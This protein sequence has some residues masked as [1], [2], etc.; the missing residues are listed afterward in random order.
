MYIRIGLVS[1][2]PVLSRRVTSME[3]EHGPAA[4]A[5]SDSDV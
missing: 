4:L 3:D 5:Q 1:S 2:F